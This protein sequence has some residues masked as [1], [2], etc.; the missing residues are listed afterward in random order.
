[1]N[2][3]EHPVVVKKSYVNGGFFLHRKEADPL[4]PHHEYVASGIAG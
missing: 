4:C 1:M 2:V 3:F